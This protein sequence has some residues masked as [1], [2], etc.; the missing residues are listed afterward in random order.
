MKTADLCR[1]EITTTVTLSL[2]DDCL[3]VESSYFDNLNCQFDLIERKLAPFINEVFHTNEANKFM[4]VAMPNVLYD[5]GERID[6]KDITLTT[7]I[8]IDKIVRLSVLASRWNGP[9]SVTVRITSI[10]ELH[11]FKRNILPYHQKLQKVVFHFYFEDNN[12]AYPN[13][14]LRNF[15]LDHVRS[16]YFALF[17]VD[18]FPSPINTHQSLQTAFDRHPQLVEKLNDKTMFVLPAWE[19]NTVILEE[20]A[21]ASRQSYPD[22]KEMLLKTI[23]SNNTD[24][25]IQTFQHDYKRG[26]RSTNYQ[27]WI[28]SKTDVSYPIITEFGYEPYV[29]GSKEGI[30]QFYP[31]FR[32]YGFN[33]QS[34]YLELHYAKYK[35]EALRD[36]FIF[37]VNHPPT[38]KNE[39]RA[40]LKLNEKCIKH[41]LD[42]LA[43]E[44][45]AGHLDKEMEAPGFTR[46]QMKSKKRERQSRPQ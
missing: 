3:K 17:D 39:R 29:V 37:H 2:S 36:F 6:L 8:S 41:F 43:M 30:P 22:T 23:A 7:Q 16:E 1:E 24:K 28:S 19:I 18:L 10:A 27:R 31:D 40:M 11:Q 13:N 32:G 35:L 14:I 46:W 20:D 34:F 5:S 9:A 45:G 15:A 44:Y 25:Q 33:K 21:A 42:H 38:Y 12:R 26:Q 4:V